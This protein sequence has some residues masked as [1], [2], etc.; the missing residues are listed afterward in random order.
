MLQKYG[1]Y[2]QLAQTKPFFLTTQVNHESNRL[3]LAGH[4][5]SFEWTAAMAC[6]VF[7]VP[8]VGGINLWKLHH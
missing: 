5:D 1:L 3:L 6:P 8:S 4:S 2:P 7:A